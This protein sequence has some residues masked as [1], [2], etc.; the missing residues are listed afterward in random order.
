VV[1][2]GLTLCAHPASAYEF[3]V[4]SRTIGQSYQLPSF[5]LLGAELWLARRRFTTSLTLSV[6][7][8][9]DLRRRRRRAH[10]GAVDRGPVVWLT[11][12][13]RVDHDFGEWTVG[14]L[15]VD[16]QPIDAL[17][18]VPELGASSLGLDLLYGYLAV[19]GL[20]GRVDLRLGRQLIFDPLDWGAVDGVTA[21]VHTRWHLALEAQAGL[22]VRDRSPLGVAALDLDGTDGADCREYVEGPTPGTG[23]WQIIDRSRVPGDSPLASD[24]DFCPERQAATPTVAA[25]IETERAGPIH[26]RLS[27]RRSQSRTPGVIGPVDRLDYPDLGLYPNES[28]QAPAWG[29]DEE[30]LALSGRGRWQGAAGAVE[31]WLQ[32]RWSML[33][34][35]LD[36]VGAGLRLSRGPHALEPEVARSIPTFDGD[37]IFN[38]FVVG[39]ARDLR[40]TYQLTP[41][42]GR[43][44]GF[45][46]AWLRHYGLPSPGGAEPATSPWVAGLTTGAE[47]EVTPRIRARLDLIGDDGYG[48][49]RLGATGTARWRAT[50]RL[51]VIGRLGGLSVDSD[52][53]DRL[54]GGSAVG[55]VAA[56]WAIDPGIAVHATTEV[57]SSPLAALQVRALAVLDLAFEPE[58]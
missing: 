44:R 35:V 14:T 57:A 9:G 13:L 39:P 11:A 55:Q 50:R 45:A 42:H 10:P 4:S 27:Y 48:G 56:S 15:H 51:T 53:R 24:L 32:A 33:H 17:D 54:D 46:T 29:V 25:A 5:R 37:S 47:L 36:E 21:R 38:V 7:D 58:M 23:S 52:S 31:P 40:L 12:Y 19:D 30:H 1:L 49:R 34:G 26:A 18:A 2:A 28:G 3:E 41:R 8:L 43:Y 6:W 20:A 16:G 22:K